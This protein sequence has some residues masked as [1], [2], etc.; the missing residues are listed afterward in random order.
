V[1]PTREPS[2]YH[3]GEYRIDI[4][5]GEVSLRAQH[6]KVR[7]KTFHLLSLFIQSPGEIISK[8]SLLS[9][10]WDDVH[11]DDQ[12]LFQS[13]KELRKIFSELEIIKTH[14][15][16]GY[17]WI[18]PLKREM[19]DNTGSESAQ[20]N[21]SSG[22]P[23]AKWLS[24]VVC[25]SLA[26]SLGISYALVSF[27][28]TESLK[29][30][31]LVLPVESDIEDGAY[32]WIRYGAMDQIIQNV[33]ATK[34]QI[35]WQVEDIL[36]FFSRAKIPTGDYSNKILSKL[37][38]DSGA[39]LIVELHLSGVPGEYQL[40]YTL[41]F[42]HS[43]SEKGVLFS[44]HL[45]NI[46]L[47]VASLIA[48]KNKLIVKALT[49]NRLSEFNNEL[50]A[51]AVEKVHQNQHAAASHYLRAVLDEQADNYTARRYLVEALLNT[52]QILQAQQLVEESIASLL[53]SPLHQDN[54]I[55]GLKH[56][57][58]MRF[59]QARVF[60]EQ[61]QFKQARRVLQLALKNSSESFDWLYSG[62]I[63][64]SLA[65]THYH[66]EEFPAAETF[67]K[68][69]L[70]YYRALQYAYGI[71]GVNLS[72]AETAWVQ[73]HRG[74]ATEHASRALNIANK[75]QLKDI[76]DTSNRALKRYSPG[77]RSPKKLPQGCILNCVI[78]HY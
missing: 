65:Y 48:G 78:A 29:K 9:Q 1:N 41:H 49:A 63:C 26:V 60:S 27:Y 67:F 72:L 28:N 46:F 56:L 21:P 44:E 68:Q 17:A 45:E 74:Q 23:V 13:I 66:M 70:N 24:L 47:Q 40:I 38:N 34:Q 42:S 52:Q 57:G 7:P 33:P 64:Q 77:L 61:G 36:R 2:V 54:H 20:T 19:L 75:H 32:S 31:V 15:R 76:I 12:V 5:T 39:N 4:A 50:L 30:S 16:K 53:S 6:I 51:V 18:A 62:N 14:P 35:V 37:F 59:V 8:T 69:A 25:L 11:V 55:Q 10:I 43:H 73:D 22:I 58:R 3:T 71:A